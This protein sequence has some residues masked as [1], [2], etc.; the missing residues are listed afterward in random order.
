[1]GDVNAMPIINLAWQTEFFWNGRSGSLEEQ[2]FE[3]VLNPIEMHDTW[4]NVVSKFN[5]DTMY[6]EMFE[7]AFGPNSIDSVNATKAIAQ[8]E[9]TLISAN[10]KY[11]QGFLMQP[12]FSNFDT[13]EFLGYTIFNNEVGDCFH[14][15]AEPLFGSFGT[16]QFSNNGLDSVLAPGS[17]REAVTGNPNDRGKFKIPSLRNI[18]W[19][20]P[21][22]HDGRFISLSQVIA[23]YDMGGHWSPTIDE[24]MKA[25]GVGKNWSP[26]EKQALIAFMKT[27]TDNDFINEQAHAD[28]FN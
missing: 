14:C 2:A 15:H 6:I 16:V 26:I 24:N 4:K 22:M 13:L 1:M 18:E 9:R 11:D 21:Y 19:T 8:F 23:H 3:P 5:R 25:V 28:P 17:G 10:S 27:L 7:D 20:F 12:Q